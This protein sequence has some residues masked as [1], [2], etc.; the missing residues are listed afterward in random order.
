VSTGVPASAVLGF[1]QPPEGAGR[2][3]ALLLAQVGPQV[4]PRHEVG[5]RVGEPGVVGVG[6]GLLVWRALARVL[7]GQAG[8]DDQYLAKA[9]LTVGLD[10]HS[11]DPRVERQLRQLTP[12]WGQAAPRIGLVGID[13]AKLMQQ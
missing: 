9:P 4:E 12:N 2:Q 8:R 1:A 7:D 6:L 3:L 10:H 5:R 11:G 13:R